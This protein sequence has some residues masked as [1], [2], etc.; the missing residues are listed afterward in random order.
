MQFVGSGC[1]RKP[2]QSPPLLNSSLHMNQRHFLHCVLLSLS[3]SS[4]AYSLFASVQ[5]FFSYSTDSF[6]A[7]KPLLLAAIPWAENIW[8]FRRGFRE[9]KTIFTNSQLVTEHLR[10]CTDLE[11][12]WFSQH[13]NATRVKS[14]WIQ[15]KKKKT[16]HW[17]ELKITERVVLFREN[18]TKFNPTDLIKNCNTT[19]GCL[20]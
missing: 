8:K 12:L 3:S 14:K 7:L 18:N 10:K 2:P 9:F 20:E 19:Q 16:T 17:E 13:S 1:R 11:M 5:L 4:P 6:Q 15:G